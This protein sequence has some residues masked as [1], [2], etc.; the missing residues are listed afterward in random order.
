MET[1]RSSSPET[2]GGGGQVP[3]EIKIHKQYF[4]PLLKGERK[5]LLS[6]LREEQAIFNLTSFMNKSWNW[7][8]TQ[9]WS[10]D[11]FYG[12]EYE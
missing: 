12:D 2:K 8:Q 3:K 1:L 6:A 11:S 7:L 9:G 5:L 10:I 4:V